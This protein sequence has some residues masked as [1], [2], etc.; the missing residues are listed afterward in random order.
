MNSHSRRNLFLL[1]LLLINFASAPEF[2]VY[3][4]MFVLI[5]LGSI[6]LHELG[7]AWGCLIK[8]DVQL[9][10][11]GSRFVQVRSDTWHCAIVRGLRR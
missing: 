1:P 9:R 10:R 5:L 7:H 8:V 4:V 2:L 6:Y 3:D 11:Q